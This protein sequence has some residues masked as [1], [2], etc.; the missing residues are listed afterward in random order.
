MAVIFKRHFTGGGQQLD[1][2]YCGGGKATMQKILEDIA[3]DLATLKGVGGAL[4][5]PAAVATVLADGNDAAS[6]QALANDLKAKYNAAVTLI[7]EMRTRF[8]TVQGGAI[9]TTKQA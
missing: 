5:S 2:L 1:S 3:T 9:L 8:N 6:T 4:A 7:N